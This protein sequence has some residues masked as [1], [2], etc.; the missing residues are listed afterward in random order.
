[1]Q[2][3][4]ILKLD[5]EYTI[6]LGINEWVEFEKVSGKNA[7]LDDIFGGMSITTLLQ[8]TYSCLKYCDDCDYTIAECAGLIGFHNMGEIIGTLS[9]LSVASAPKT[10]KGDT[11]KK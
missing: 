4:A 11:K 9:K 8:L 3:T 2:E 1:M 5:K 7:L 6:S 10:K